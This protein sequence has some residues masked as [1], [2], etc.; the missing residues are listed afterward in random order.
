[1]IGTILIGYIYDIFGRKVTIVSTIL[2][3]ALTIFL[4]PLA[5]PHVYP[6]LVILRIMISL[7]YLAPNCQPLI[8]DYVKKESRGRASSFEQFG[9]IFGQLF[10]FLVVIEL[11]KGMSQQTA[12]TTVSLMILGLGLVF[13]VIVKEPVRSESYI[14]HVRDETKLE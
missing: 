8:N 1:M 10:T 2:L 14:E 5:S 11:V 13:L 4:V 3:G 12:F 6:W 7:S 9:M